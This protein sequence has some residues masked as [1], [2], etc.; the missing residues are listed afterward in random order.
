ML[1]FE[2]ILWNELLHPYRFDFSDTIFLLCI[3]VI[4]KEMYLKNQNDK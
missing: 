1:I 4:T 3:S 2:I